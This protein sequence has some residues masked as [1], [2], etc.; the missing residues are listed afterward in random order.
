L[1]ERYYYHSRS[2]K[3]EPDLF[4]I[5][6]V[7]VK[8]R[9]GCHEKAIKKEAADDKREN[10]RRS[11]V[12]TVNRKPDKRNTVSRPNRELAMDSFKYALDENKALLTA[13]QN[14]IYEWL[15]NAENRKLEKNPYH[16]RRAPSKESWKTYLRQWC[17]DRWINIEDVRQH[18]KG[19]WALKD[20][21][22]AEKK[23]GS[24][25]PAK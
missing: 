10:A 13:T 25:S 6:V 4:T 20:K 15:V 22:A 5:C 8:K 7:M 24:P 11:L 16:D 1:I 9:L 21:A 3:P 17:R 18:Y 23:Y 12:A 19:Q 14:E 2:G